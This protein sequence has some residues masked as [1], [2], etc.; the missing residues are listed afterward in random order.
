MRRGLIFL[1]TDGPSV[2]AQRLHNL[3]CSQGYEVRESVGISLISPAKTPGSRALI[4]IEGDRHGGWD[5][6]KKAEQIRQFNLRLPILLITSSSSENLAIAALKARVTDYIKDT[7]S[8]ED[9]VANVNGVFDEMAQETF[10]TQPQGSESELHEEI[11]MIGTSPIMQKIKT[12]I[13]NIANSDCTVLITGETGTGKDLSAEL[14]HKASQRHQQPFVSINCAAIPETLFES[15]LFGYEKGAFTGAVSSTG[16]KL[17]Q[18]HGGTILL[19]E[20]GDIPAHSQAKLLRVIETKTV[21]RL[22]GKGT[23][24][25]NARIIAATNQEL[26]H[27]VEEGKFRSD[28]FYRLNVARLHLPPL[29]DRKE[30]IPLL[31]TH[32]LKNLQLQS[33]Q[34]VKE[35]T[36][37]ALHVLTNYSWPGNVRELRNFLEATFIYPLPQKISFEH[38]PEHL[39]AKL[40]IKEGPTLDESSIITEALLKTNWNK[41]K[42]AQVLKWSRMTLYRKMEQHGIK[43]KFT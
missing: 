3:L 33:P 34:E 22:G 19:D 43:K 9:I 37:D 28:L 14:I 6:V 30:D 15:E 29:R 5:G 1:I 24:P 10:S 32:Y 25:L 35:F 36:K 8:L 17:E 26:E 40:Q 23:I 18:A 4:I 2:R 13:K 12:G 39:H 27:L 42:A 41:S 31:L 7:C 16:G 20:V 21:Q 38:F 11:S